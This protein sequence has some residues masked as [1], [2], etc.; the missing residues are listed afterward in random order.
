MNAEALR[1]LA[2]REGLDSFCSF[3]EESDGSLLLSPLEAEVPLDSL[4]DVLAVL[5]ILRGDRHSIGQ[6]FSRPFWRKACDRM[7][8]GGVMVKGRDGAYGLAPS[9]FASFR[10]WAVCI[11]L[12]AL[13]AFYEKREVRIADDVARFVRGAE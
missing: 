12:A 1:D 3:E 9:A 11:F 4:E 5:S 8:E 13:S 2:L 7:V 10:Y 6:E